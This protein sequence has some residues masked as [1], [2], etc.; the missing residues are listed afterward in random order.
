MEAAL[1]RRAVQGGCGLCRA[2]PRLERAGATE[3]V[4]L[5]DTLA[6]IG[7]TGMT[8]SNVMGCGI[9][10]GKV[11]SYRGVKTD[12]NLLPKLQVDVV[13]SEVDPGLVVAAASKALHT[14]SAGDGKIFVSGIEDVM[15]I[16]TGQ[17]GTAALDMTTE[18]AG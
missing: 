18:V 3:F 5:K 16:S 8:V 12:V 4:R 6:K 1:L 9:E 14:G 11:G 10:K 15:R 2:W 13:V 7:V 17:T